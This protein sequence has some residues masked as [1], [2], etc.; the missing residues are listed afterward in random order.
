MTDLNEMMNDAENFSDPAKF[1]DMLDMARGEKTEEKE[2]E[3]TLEE[4][5][6]I[7]EE[8]EIA[9]EEPKKEEPKDD[10]I[11]IPKYRFDQS[12]AEK[13]EYKRKYEELY[14]LVEDMVKSKAAPAEE[15]EEDFEPIDDAAH[16]RYTKEIESVK[17]TQAE[18]LARSERQALADAIVSGE[19]AAKS[20]YA[21][22][23]SAFTHYAEVKIQEVMALGYNREEAVKSVQ[24]GILNTA[25][26]AVQNKRD[27]GDII[28]NLA[29]ASGY[30]PV[31][32]AIK[33][34]KLTE[35]RAKTERRPSE[36]AASDT[37]NMDVVAQFKKMSKKGTVSNDDF[38]KLLARAR[39]EA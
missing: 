1:Q 35:N 3:D 11:N 16:K 10:G 19:Q 18:I 27:I 9:A 13:L 30:K 24:H 34:D 8:E 39:G 22:Y 21:D 4:E 14:N 37:S 26:G 32:G 6:E 31:T 29:K 5:A 17:K 20:K 36:R 2:E 15:E 7:A 38:K 28:Y 23:D 12:Q 33:T 25:I